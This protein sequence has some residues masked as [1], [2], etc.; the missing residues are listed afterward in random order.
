MQHNPTDVYICSRK[1]FQA[2]Y[3]EAKMLFIE[4]TNKLRNKSSLSASFIYP[5]FSTWIANFDNAVQILSRQELHSFVW[6]YIHYQFIL[7]PKK[8]N[9]IN[10]KCLLSSRHSGG[11]FVLNLFSLFHTAVAS[12]LAHALCFT[13]HH[14]LSSLFIQCT[15]MSLNICMEYGQPHSGLY[16]HMCLLSTQRRCRIFLCACRGFD[17]GFTLSPILVLAKATR[18]RALSWTESSKQKQ[19]DKHGPTVAAVIAT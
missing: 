5:S 8:V 7:L 3:F 9:M 18:W 1:L 14:V 16:R 13:E 10:P 19:L 17:R 6:L 15:L 11:S 4:N 2:F 12:I